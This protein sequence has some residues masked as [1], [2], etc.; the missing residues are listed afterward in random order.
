MDEN[1]G[2]PCSICGSTDRYSDGRCKGCKRLYYLANRDHSLRRNARWE[3]DNRDIRKSIKQRRRARLRSAPGSFTGDEW[4]ALCELYD[5]TCLGCLKRVGYNFLTVDHVVP[6][7]MGGTNWLYNLQP[8]CGSCNSSKHAKHID[9]R[10][11]FA[12]P[13]ERLLEYVK[14]R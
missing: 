13:E 3:L 9:Y 11:S 1:D 10:T 14:E 6:L 4:V 12:I 5:F 7:S 2:L 8:L